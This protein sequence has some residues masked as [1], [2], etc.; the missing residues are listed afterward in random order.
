MTMSIFKIP[1]SGILILLLSLTVSAQQQYELNDGW[2]AMR[3]S[4]IKL[5][6]EVISNIS[7]PPT[8]WLPA[9][10]PGTVLTTQLQNKQ[11]PDPFY[12]MNNEQIPDLY[13]TGSAYYTYWFVKD[14]T[15]DAPETNEKIW[16]L[17]RGVNNS[18]DVYLNGHKVNDHQY[19]SMYLR[20]RYDL[21]PYMAKDGHNRLAVI[22]Y[23]PDPAGNPNGGQG[24]DGT[25]AHNLT[26]Q[27]TAG[28]DWIQPV[29]DRNTGIWDKVFI[30]KTRQVILS[31]THVV[32]LVPGIRNTEGRQE[33]ATIKVSAELENTS[34]ETIKGTLQYKCNGSKRSVK[35]TL[36]PHNQ[37]KVNL[38]ELVV[39]NPELWWPNGY[40]AQP[41]YELTTRFLIDRKI[42]DEEQVTFGIRQLQAE[43]NKKT[44][45]REL[46]VNGQRIFIKGGNRILSDALLRFSPER[47]D[48]EVR[49]HR[50]MNLNMI[51]IWGGG[52]TERPDF[53]DEC[54][55][56]GL[57]IMQ[58]LWVSGDC[59]GRWYDPLKLEDTLARRN[60]PDDHRLFI[61]S[62]ADQVKMLRNH[63][64]LAFWCGGNE[65]QPP[66]DILKALK[67]TVM[68]QLDNTRYFFDHSNADSM[69]YKSGDGPY[70]IQPINYFWEHRSF[71]FNSEVGSVGIG[72]YE[73]LE[74]FI[75]KENIVVPEYDIASRKWKIDPVW[76][77]HKYCGYDSAIESYGHAAD[78]KDFARK[79]QLVNYDQYRALME[80]AT[81]HM[82]DWYTGV[83]VWKTQNPWT[84]M[85][86]Q[87]YDVYLDPN[88]SMYGLSNGAKPIH[89]MYDPVKHSVLIANNGF[90]KLNKMH[91][92]VTL[93]TKDGVRDDL[94]NSFVDVPPGTCNEY[95]NVN[96]TIEELGKNDGIFLSLRLSDVVTGKL[97]DENL[98]WL[99]NADGRYPI[100][101]SIPKVP[102]TATANLISK[103][104][105]EVTISNPLTTTVAFF[106]RI[107]LVDATTKKRILPAFCNNNYISVIPGGQ[108]TI[109]VTFAP[110]E[111]ITPMIS[112]E[113][114]NVDNQLIPIKQTNK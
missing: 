83:M 70:T 62:A 51:R 36:L 96:N 40:G 32:T 98:Y 78:V 61:T 3:A 110:Q 91:M 107:S 9:T 16:A 109:Q 11:I 76:K 2:K 55:K 42:S 92:W 52:I 74:K 4:D 85:V 34:D 15:E 66:A 21:T 50:D 25:I 28:W 44:Q 63:P 12:G 101:D 84:A 57:L 38:P 7:H 13:K 60:Y 105:I 6:G 37:M 24:G 81:S 43:W 56:Y 80:G 114:W 29:R 88:A 1:V 46:H 64:S 19:K 69:S 87:M 93:Y 10:V 65:I 67:D 106:N 33:P 41:M 86:G 68:P 23:P 112:I 94:L 72:D 73:S 8:N 103:G 54:D 99:P 113:G 49:Y 26:A 5:T 75:P 31:N 39:D 53:Y 104:V 89:I 108:N 77:Y 47:Y 20:Q 48:A 102:V 97:A 22:V 17:F 111:G 71:P 95:A 79:A 45:S 30:H 82:W 27:Y 35:V 18:C 90:S 14:F 100:L 59:N 58:D